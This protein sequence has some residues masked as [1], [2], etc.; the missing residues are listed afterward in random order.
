MLSAKNRAE[1]VTRDGFSSNRIQESD[2]SLKDEEEKRGSREGEVG[3]Q[4]GGG[5]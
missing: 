1:I 3:S 5:K 4:E 2:Q